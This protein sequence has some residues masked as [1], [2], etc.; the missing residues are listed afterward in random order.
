MAETA[1][2]R[3]HEVLTPTHA[4][5]DLLQA[6]AARQAVLTARPGIVINCAAVSGLEACADDREAAFTLNA[7]APAA[8]SRACASC[9]ARFIHLSTDYVLCG[10][11]PGLKAEDAPC[12]PIC[13]YGHSKLEGERRIA[14]ANPQALILRVSWLCG[15][16]ARPGFPEGIAARALAGQPL[17]AIDDKDSLPTD[18]YELAEAALQL[19]ERRESGTLHVCSTGDPVSWWQNAQIALQT[20]V[21]AGTLPQLP[22]LAAQKLDEVPF[23]REPRP[24]HTAMDNARLRALGIHMS[25]AEETIRRAVARYCAQLSAADVAG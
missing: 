3:G 19:A 4:E 16:P 13:T 17:A 23:F 9:G 1:R 18:V 11:T 15:N 21:D 25:S 12:A 24:R 6:E 20:L 7:A 8:L 2:R 22:E 5:C 14:A 10:R